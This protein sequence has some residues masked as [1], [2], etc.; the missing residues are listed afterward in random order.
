MRSRSNASGTPQAALDTVTLGPVYE[1]AHHRVPEAA[2]ANRGE[3]GAELMA[4]PTRP[5]GRR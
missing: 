5:V 3:M 2:P 1:H 4:A